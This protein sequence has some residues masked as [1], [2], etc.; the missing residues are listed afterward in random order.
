MT[1]SILKAVTLIL[2]IQSL[3]LLAAGEED[4][5]RDLRRIDE[6][7]LQALVEQSKRPPSDLSIR[8][9]TDGIYADKHRDDEILSQIYDNV[10]PITRTIFIDVG[11][12]GGEIPVIH[13]V[14]NRSTIIPFFEQGMKPLKIEAVFMKTNRN[15]DKKPRFTATHIEE[16][17]N[18]VDF[19]TN[20]LTGWNTLEIQ[21]EGY[22][23]LVPLK[24]VAGNTY[25]LSSKGIIIASGLDQQP[26]SEADRVRENGGFQTI[27]SYTQNTNIKKALIEFANSGVTPNGK[28]DKQYDLELFQVPPGLLPRVVAYKAKIDGANYVLLR[29]NGILI[30]PDYRYSQPAR[31]LTE[32]IYAYAI[33]VKDSGSFISIEYKNKRF[34]YQLANRGILNALQP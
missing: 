24:V 33:P 1:K 32:N 3:S 13:L 6:D 8:K 34:I 9:I 31:T 30:E 16:T 26:N 25:D 22:N 20:A 23:E 18:V 4:A 15:K 12:K 14:K 7:K 17:D 19:V 11:G 27:Q 28:L 21:F 10:K 5:P 2:L 29:S